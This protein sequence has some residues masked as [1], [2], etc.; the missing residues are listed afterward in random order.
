MPPSSVTLGR[1]VPRARPTHA[2]ALRVARVGPGAPLFLCGGHG[3]A[4][5]S[6]RILPT[7]MHWSICGARS[8]SRAPSPQ[9]FNRL[10]DHRSASVEPRRAD[11]SN[12][13]GGA[14][15]LAGCW[16]SA[17]RRGDGVQR[18]PAGHHACSTTSCTTSR[19]TQLQ[20]SEAAPT[21]EAPVAD[22]VDHLPV[23][24]LCGSMGQTR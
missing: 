21:P 18:G 14:P 5:L 22:N 8:T 11:P 24:G 6:S 16:A 13:C 23:A 10:L 2:L 19:H 9:R 12:R 7:A 1:C 4:L 3:L 15:C 17:C 20:S